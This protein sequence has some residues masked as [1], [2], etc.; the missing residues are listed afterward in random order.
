MTDLE[1]D[2]ASLLDGLQ[3]SGRSR[4]GN[5]RCPVCHAPSRPGEHAIGCRLHGLLAGMREDAARWRH[6]ARGT[7]YREVGLGTLKTN[8]PLADGDTVMVYRAETDGAIGVRAVSEFLDGRFE[9][10]D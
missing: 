8:G 1:R 10:L 5:A 4:E 7:T 2:L 6:R 9:P 3:W